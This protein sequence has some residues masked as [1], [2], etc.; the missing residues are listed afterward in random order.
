MLPTMRSL[1]QA[2]VLV[3][4]CG[5]SEPF[6]GMP[7]GTH[8][9]RVPGV[10]AK[11]TDNPL[12]DQHPSWLPDGSAILYT[13]ESSFVE[14]LDRCL[15]LLPPT[16]GTRTR[17]ICNTSA[18]QV[19]STETYGPSAVS[20]SGQLAFLY[21]Q[22]TPGRQPPNHRALRVAPLSDPQTFD[23]VHPLPFSVSGLTIDAV[24]D[25][26]WLSQT[27][28]AYLGEYS[29]PNTTARGTVVVLIDLRSSAPPAA[30][31]GT[32]GVVSF[33]IGEAPETII[34]TRPGDSRIFQL[35]LA[36][37]QEAVVYDFSPGF[38][39]DIAAQSQ[40]LATTIGN[41][42]I[43]VDLSSQTS[44]TIIAAD[45]SLRLRNP[46]LSVSGAVVAESGSDLWLFEASTP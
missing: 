23:M 30:I 31:P 21:T 3:T 20:S 43:T 37:G 28:F 44:D 27:R 18:G 11:L 13:F 17:E 39:G 41:T 12:V 6:T 2:A 25:I 29:I 35:A 33:G 34:L 46:A 38:P 4:A 15:A 16:G 42:L 22:S 19:D 40:R 36:S 1:V 9:P 45:T 7:Q 24:N 8:T 5:H 10:P 32:T 14:N 26:H